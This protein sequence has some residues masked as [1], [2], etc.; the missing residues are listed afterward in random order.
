[1]TARDQLAAAGLLEEELAQLRAGI[2]AVNPVLPLSGYRRMEAAT[3]WPPTAIGDDLFSFVPYAASFG[4]PGSGFRDD[5]MS[6]LIGVSD[7]GGD[8][9]RF[10][11]ISDSSSLSPEEI[12]RVMPG[13]GEGPRPPVLETFVEE[14]PL[15]QSR[16]VETTERGIVPVGGDFAYDMG[17]ALRQDYEGTIDFVIRYDDPADRRQQMLYSGSMESGQRDL[18]WQSPALTGFETGE[19]YEVVIE[20]SQA[21]SGD[22][23]FEHRDKLEFQPTLEIW[24]SVLSKPPAERSE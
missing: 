8:A 11:Q 15:A 9:W 13:H 16:W 10:I 12:D 5:R 22:R 2:S 3:P 14:R 7:D 21:E 20:G 4:P 23:L 18:R 1:L 19:T 6:Y 24:R 17:F